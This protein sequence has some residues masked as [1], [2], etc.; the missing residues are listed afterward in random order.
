MAIEIEKKYLIQSEHEQIKE[1]FKKKPIYIAQGYLST[2]AKKIVRVRIKDKKGF[3][4]IKG[5]QVGI[6]KPEY[7]YKIPLDDAKAMM[8]MCDVKIKKYRYIH[9]SVDNF[10]WEIDVFDEANKGLIIAEI[11]LPSEDTKFIL[12][13]WI[14]KDVSLD[15]R[16]SN[17]NLA[18]NPI[19]KFS[20]IKNN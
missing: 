16:Y 9:K 4:T 13:E 7:E 18:L 15:L 8:D 17:S 1:I 5:L 11:E 19:S 14:Q 20:S 12:P 10:L 3:L 6:S 2:D